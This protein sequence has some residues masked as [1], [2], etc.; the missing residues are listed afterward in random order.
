MARVTSPLLDRFPALASLPR[1]A[2]G[3]V[4][5]PVERWALAEGGELWV[6]RDDLN[7][8]ELGGNKVRALEWLLGGVGAGDV[9]V[10][11]GGVGS[12]HVLATAV[13]ARRLGARTWAVRWPHDMNPVAEQVAARIERECE[14]A[15]VSS[16]PVAIARLV[17]WRAA[18]RLRGRPLRWVPFGGSAPLGVLGHLD[19][20]LEL[21]GQVAAGELPAPRRLI[22]PLG[23]GGTTAGLALGLALAGLRCEVVAA[24]VGPR[25]GA[26]RG[27]ALRLAEATRRLV[28][29]RTGQ[30]IPPPAP[31]RVVH[32]VYGGAYG[33]E[34]AAGTRAADA[35]RRS[36]GIRLDA[37]YGAKACAAALALAGRAEGP[38]LFWVTFDGRWLEDQPFPAPVPQTPPVPSPQPPGGRI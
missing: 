33:R 15:P 25:L 21:A 36:L 37:T 14:R 12:T 3:V 18:A 2:L 38:S 6:K 35:L 26:T 11:L 29:A 1:A 4:R 30:T 9:V 13:H 22:V 32:D 10:T 31:I 16:P 27:R 17:A 28:R 20:A 7:A 19:A 5:S 8:P 23:S 34:L 24:R